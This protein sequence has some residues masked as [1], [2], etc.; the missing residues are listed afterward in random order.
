MKTTKAMAKAEMKAPEVVADSAALSEAITMS[1]E[2]S[3]FAAGVRAWFARAQALQASAAETLAHAK[4]FRDPINLEEDEQIRGFARACKVEIERNKAHFVGISGALH[5][6]HKWAVGQ[7]ALAVSPLEQAKQIADA[8]HQRYEEAERRRAR[9]EAER[10]RLAEEAR[11]RAEREQEAQAAEQRA[12]ELEQ[13]SE[14]LSAR[15][16]QYV[17]LRVVGNSPEASARAAGYKNPSQAAVRL[18]ESQKIIDAIRTGEQV[19]AL[20]AQ[21]QAAASAPI[22]VP[23]VEIKAQVAEGSSRTTW[24]AEVY[25][26]DAFIV[27]VVNR[28]HGIPLVV[29][30]PNQKVL[31]EYARSLK[32]NL[33]RWP[34]VRA[35]KKVTTI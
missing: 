34:G 2:L 4:A 21:A 10:L 8:G 20:R 27:A 13:T 16:Q 5:R 30:E 28:A 23:E 26:L 3:A 35:V 7:S 31:N 11:I 17:A 14:A 29:L 9:E 25:D 12:L 6:G 19:K 32:E 15:E 1:G 33:S 22:L 18:S 24:S